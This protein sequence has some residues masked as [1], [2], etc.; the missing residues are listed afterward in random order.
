MNMQYIDLH[1]F[2]GAEVLTLKAGPAPEPR[3]HEVLIKVHAFGINRPDIFQR[4]GN[5]PAPKDAS[6]LLGLEVAGVIQQVGSQVRKWKVGDEVCALTPGGGYAEYCTTPEGHCLPKPK[7]LSMQEAAGIPET[8]FTTWSNIFERGKLKAA[9]T[10]LV[11]GGSSGIGVSA[12]QLAHNFGAR[13]ICTAGSEEKLEACRKLGADLAINYKTQDFAE[14]I[15]KFTEKK[16]V[17]LILDMIGAGY[18]AKNME[19]LSLDG[20]MVHIATLQ[21]AETSINLSKLMM[22]RQTITGSTLRAQSVENKARIAEELL[23]NVWPLF[24]AEKIKVPIDRVF[25]LNQIQ[26][27]HRRMESREHIGKIIVSVLDH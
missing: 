3:D 16:G 21:G 15:K 1:G 24:E 20:R 18:F 12:I 4:S 11:H 25:S 17:N 2:G 19:I 14:E 6:P 10:F 22:M 5:Y 13:V 23:K 26:E 7:N 27:A 8:Y 9:E